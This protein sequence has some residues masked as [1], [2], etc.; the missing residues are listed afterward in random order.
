MT[1]ARAVAPLIPLAETPPKVKFPAW[2]DI[3]TILEF[4]N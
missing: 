3:L 4:A 1:E 2:R